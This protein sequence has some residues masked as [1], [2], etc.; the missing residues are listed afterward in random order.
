MVVRKS[1]KA[2]AEVGQ[3]L[4]S[5][6]GREPALFLDV[7]PEGGTLTVRPEALDICQT[8]APPPFSD[9][10]AWRQRSSKE[11]AWAAPRVAR[12][13]DVALGPG[14]VLARTVGS[15]YPNASDALDRAQ[16]G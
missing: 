5:F 12:A 7:D 2:L 9:V 10:G 15:P 14:E 13:R 8:P 3:S 4:S 6:G 16:G 1:A 11:V